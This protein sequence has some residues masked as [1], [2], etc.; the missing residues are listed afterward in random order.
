[1]SE[2]RGPVIE[3]VT[4]VLGAV[5]AIAVTLRLWARAFI[6]KSL[7]ADDGKFNFPVFT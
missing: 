1:M 5:T 4:V 2:N 7:G 6:V 3:W